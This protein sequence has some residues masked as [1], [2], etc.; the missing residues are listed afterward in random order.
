MVEPQVLEPCC[1]VWAGGLH[2]VYA[3]T[4]ICVYLVCL[5]V[6][7]LGECVCVCVYVRACVCMYV[8]C[9]CVPGVSVWHVSVC[10]CVCLHLCGPGLCAWCL[11]V[12]VCLCL[13]V[14][15]VS[16]CIVSRG[17]CV[18]VCE[19]RGTW[20]QGLTKAQLAGVVSAL[21]RPRAGTILQ[22]KNTNSPSLIL[23]KK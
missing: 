6:W 11:G 2:G 4:C 16:A 8:A 3:G 17:V 5:H 10:L 19:R 9:L 22:I 15:G 14:P 12:C 1:G 23:P 7:C 20:G 18:S 13:C 21:C